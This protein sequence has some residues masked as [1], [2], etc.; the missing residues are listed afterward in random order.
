MLFCLYDD[1]LKP[2]ISDHQRSWG[3]E[4][5]PWKGPGPP[6]L[7]AADFFTSIH[8]PPASI[9]FAPIK[10]AFAVTVEPFKF[11]SRQGGGAYELS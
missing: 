5:G 6:L 2:K 3:Y 4:D 7:V 11:S 8:K 1:N 10:H 9:R